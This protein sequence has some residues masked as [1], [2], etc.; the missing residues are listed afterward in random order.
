MN[1]TEPVTLQSLVRRASVATKLANR[2]KYEILNASDAEIYRHRPRN[3]MNLTT[4]IN[5]HQGSPPA[6]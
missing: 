3:L 5:P 4:H 6:A 2:R 1:Q